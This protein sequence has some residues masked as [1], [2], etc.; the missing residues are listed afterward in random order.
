MYALDHS[1][2]LLKTRITTGKIT[3]IPELGITKVTF[4]SLASGWRAGQHVRLRILS[5][6]LGL[7]GWTVAHPFTIANASDRSGLT[8]LVKKA[9]TWTTKLY[10]A[11]GRAGYYN[12]E[13][14]K[15]VDRDIKVI[16][17]GPYGGL[18]NMIM[19][20]YSSA[21]L[22]GGGSGVS[23]VLSMAEELAS[24]LR[25]QTCSLRFVEIIWITQEECGH[26]INLFLSCKTLI[27]LSASIT[28]LV[29]AFNSILATV[30][31]IPGVVV[32]IT[33]FYS[34]A[35]ST[36]N[37]G[38]LNSALAPGLTIRAGRPGLKRMLVGLCEMTA[39]IHRPRGV[40]VGVCGPEELIKDAR[41]AGRSIDS[42]TRRTCGGVEIHEE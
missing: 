27:P 3:V 15:A 13:P 1:V 34:R 19:A 26:F 37:A 38:P 16:V 42:R 9:G 20:S 23:F 25:K 22:V 31:P 6:E 11:A 40:A 10:D 28:P 39:S 21:M 32:H 41:G 14:G 8:L 29:P 30:G 24:D 7:L 4:P 2:R 5:A 17:E 33:I 35:S 18:G 12:E 36:K